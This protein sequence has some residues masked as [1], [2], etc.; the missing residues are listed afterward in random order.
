MSAVFNVITYVL[1]THRLSP[2]IQIIMEDESKY[3]SFN[4]T[5]NNKRLG[6]KYGNVQAK[7][8]HLYFFFYIYTLKPHIQHLCEYV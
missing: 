1:I 5:K 7:L 3:H 4:M 8:H 2:E 6:S